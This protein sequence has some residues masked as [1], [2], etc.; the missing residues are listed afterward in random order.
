MIINFHLTILHVVAGL[1]LRT[2][3]FLH[4]TVDGLQSELMFKKC[5]NTDY[6]VWNYNTNNYTSN[7]TLSRLFFHDAQ[8]VAADSK[9]NLLNSVPSTNM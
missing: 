8:D 9:L 2:G 4:G 1:S 7:Y 3:W 6:N 5:T